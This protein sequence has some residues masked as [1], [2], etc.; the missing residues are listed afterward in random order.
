MAYPLVENLHTRGILHRT[1]AP[2]PNLSPELQRT[3]EGH[4]RRL[5][6]ELDYVGTMAVEFFQTED[7][8]LANEMAP[9]VHNSGHWTQDGAPTCQ[10]ENHLRAILG[11]PL[12]ETDPPRWTVMLNLLGKLPPVERV[13]EEPRAHLHLYGKSPRPGRKIGHVNVVADSLEEAME[14]VA[15]IEAALPEGAGPV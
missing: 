11:L 15:R 6:E 8:L 9:R 14:V 13:L 12:G 7:G 2:A 5:M 3:A 1:I 4:V 10:F